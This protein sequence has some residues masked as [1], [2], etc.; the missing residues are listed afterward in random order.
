M[1]KFVTLDEYRR[2]LSTCKGFSPIDLIAEFLPGLGPVDDGIMAIVAFRYVRR[3]V[4]VEALRD[5]SLGSADG[6]ALLLRVIGSG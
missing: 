1:S 3:R 5:S 2:V 4:G 6:F